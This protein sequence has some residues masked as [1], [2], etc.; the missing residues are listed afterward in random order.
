M[1]N[2][3]KLLA[4]SVLIPSGLTVAATATNVAIPKKFFWIRYD[5]I[6]NFKLRNG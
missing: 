4:K 3:Q 5:K 2:T 6:Y 1:K